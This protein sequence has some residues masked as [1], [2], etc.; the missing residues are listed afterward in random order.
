MAG[1]T[2]AKTPARSQQLVRILGVLRDRAGGPVS[3]AFD[4]GQQLVRILGVL[5][6]VDRLGGTSQRAE[7]VV[8]GQRRS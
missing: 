2:R 4:Q 6:D 8:D 1:R 5:R 3:A 7:R